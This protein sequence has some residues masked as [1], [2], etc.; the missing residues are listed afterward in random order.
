M[1]KASVVTNIATDSIWFLWPELLHFP[2][3]VSTLKSGRNEE[4]QLIGA[5]KYIK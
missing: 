4:G 1:I 3:F 2:V 5:T